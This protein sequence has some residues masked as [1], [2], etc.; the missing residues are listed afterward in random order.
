M[1]CLNF[2]ISKQ[3]INELE[4]RNKEPI[5]LILFFDFKSILVISEK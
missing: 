4:K 1:A 5:S 2:Y 3:I